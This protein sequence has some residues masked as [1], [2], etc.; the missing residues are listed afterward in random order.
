MCW[1]EEWGNPTNINLLMSVSKI[2]VPTQDQALEMPD[3]CLHPRHGWPEASNHLEQC[4]NIRNAKQTNFQVCW[5]HIGVTLLFV[6]ETLLTEFRGHSRQPICLCP[7]DSP[8]QDHPERDLFPEPRQFSI[9]G[10]WQ[11]AAGSSWTMFSLK[12]AWIWA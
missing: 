4:I 6:S 8:F 2:R 3:R 5:P 9:P 12:L 11:A 1:P 7:T 10:S